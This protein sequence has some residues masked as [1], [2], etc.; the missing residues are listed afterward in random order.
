MAKQTKHNKTPKKSPQTRVKVG[1]GTIHAPAKQQNTAFRR[2]A[3][4]IFV[5]LFGAIGVY[6]LLRSRAGV[7][8][9]GSIFT[10]G[11]VISAGG[12]QTTPQKYPVDVENSS[13]GL[14]GAV[15]TMSFD[16]KKI[17]Y[18][19]V[20]DS[21]IKVID[22]TT[23]LQTN[24]FLP[25][26]KRMIQSVSYIQWS[27]NATKLA[28]QYQIDTGI[29]RAFVM[30]ADGTDVVDLPELW[31]VALAGWL[32]DASGVVYV[33]DYD[34]LCTFMLS[35]KAENCTKLQNYAGYDATGGT[36]R[37]RLA[38]NGSTVAIVYEH[39]TAGA[40]QTK[41]VTTTVS[42][43]ALSELVTARAEANITAIAWSPDS[44]KLAYALQGTK[45][46][47]GTELHVF[48]TGTKA[49]ATL[50]P[51]GKGTG[52]FQLDWVIRDEDRVAQQAN[53]APG[54]PKL[55]VDASP[56]A[57]SSLVKGAVQASGA[58][59]VPGT[60]TAVFLVAR[61]DASSPAQLRAIDGENTEARDVLTL[62]DASATWVFDG[63]SL[64]GKWLALHKVTALDTRQFM[65]E[66]WLVKPD[67]SDL[68]MMSRQ[69]VGNNANGYNL[70]WNQ[71]STG[72]YY[73]VPAVGEAKA[74]IC[75]QSAT[76]VSRNCTDLIDTTGAIVGA[77]NIHYS[78]SKE[79]MFILTT[80]TTAS[81]QSNIFK[82]DST[83]G[84]AT[85]IAKMPN[86]TI[87][88]VSWSPDGTKFSVT[89]NGQ[90]G[91]G[92]FTLNPD[93]TNLTQV[94]PSPETFVWKTAA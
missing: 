11:Y 38:P 50:T 52:I 2:G 14:R 55:V 83:S 34:H 21:K 89:L 44:S 26:T 18:Y 49:D 43:S 79:G 58:S 92:V 81:N 8:P 57:L 60:N 59:M 23:T 29:M 71:D 75:S 20:N 12:V 68:R 70:A 93:G 15:P 66:N 94:L 87:S 47:E 30:N 82:V 28:V 73:V 53:L 45:E 31:N 19:D 65:Q 36:I 6:L 4:L 39:D 35:S 90:A 37:A 84:T 76:G 1:S 91:T 78:L 46:G 5:A 13:L 80:H 62:P 27:Q 61:T 85:E 56:R 40:G 69:V 3:L 25:S 74:Q 7:I 86:T 16:G 63:A 24:E 41:I 72:F 10:G 77:Q 22:A 51:G 32:P 42:G 9:E 48:D 88:F 64:D 67:G 33:K 17:A 54:E